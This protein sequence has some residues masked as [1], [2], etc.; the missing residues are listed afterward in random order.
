MTKHES[1]DK[2]AGL[3]LY[4]KEKQP[5]IQKM[6]QFES[7]QPLSLIEGVLCSKLAPSVSLIS[8]WNVIAPGAQLWSSWL[9]GWIFSS[10][11]S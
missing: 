8:L 3:R 11:S 6:Y 7:S 1:S 9:T 4:R 10:G 5:L 2:G